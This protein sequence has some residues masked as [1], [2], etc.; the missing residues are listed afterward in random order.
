MKVQATLR[1]LGELG[2]ATD[3]AQ[4]GD[5]MGAQIL[6]GPADEVAHVEQGLLG[7]S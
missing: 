6:Q 7:R 5:R 3:E 2:E 1:E 4:A